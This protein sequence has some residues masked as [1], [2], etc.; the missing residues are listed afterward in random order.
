M[1][2]IH[3]VRWRREVC[4]WYEPAHKRNVLG[5]VQGSISPFHDEE[6]V[7]IRSSYKAT[8]QCAT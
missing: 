2:M 8:V 7:A 6:E 3:A 4:G 1:D 5:Y